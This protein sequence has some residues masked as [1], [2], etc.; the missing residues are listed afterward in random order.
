MGVIDLLDLT[1]AWHT[2]LNDISPEKRKANLLELGLIFLFVMLFFVVSLIGMGLVFLLISILKGLFSEMSDI[3]NFQWMIY[4]LII[5]TAFSF[6]VQA[7][8]SRTNHDETPANMW[9]SFKHHFSYFLA[10]TLAIWFWAYV[11]III[12]IFILIQTHIISV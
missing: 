12:I 9:R 1:R 11:V 2:N 3:S 10:F 5:G 8:P 7:V 6:F 4:G